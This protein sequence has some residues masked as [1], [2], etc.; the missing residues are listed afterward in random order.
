M[1][2]ALSFIT[3]ILVFAGY[4]QSRN[5]EKKSPLENV[6]AIILGTTI[7]MATA[8]MLLKMVLPE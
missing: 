2:K 8:G 1:D 5:V 6:L 7:I 3:A 4:L